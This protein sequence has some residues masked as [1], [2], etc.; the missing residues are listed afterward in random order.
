[1]E[2]ISLNPIL[3]F[4]EIILNKKRIYSSFLS[5]FQSSIQSR[6]T[7]KC[8]TSRI[9]SE[10]KINDFDP[11]TYKCKRVVE[12]LSSKDMEMVLKRLGLHHTSNGG[13]FPSRLDEND[14][15]ALFESRSPRLDE[16]K[17]AFD[18]FDKNKDGFIEAWELWKVLCDLGLDEGSKMEDCRRMIGAFD[19][20]GDGM[21]D[22][23]E[24]VKFMENSSL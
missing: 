20:N 16:V 22:F 2:N 9:L 15:F 5:R 6:L 14:V 8:N 11:S 10:K 24:F 4:I 19:E 18:V 12:T 1:M 7:A 23:D 17:E 13:N 21:I 3:R